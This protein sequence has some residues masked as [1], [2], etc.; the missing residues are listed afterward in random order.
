MTTQN[1]AKATWID[2]SETGTYVGTPFNTKGDSKMPAQ[3]QGKLSWIEEAKKHVG[4]HENV[5]GNTHPSLALW[6]QE[7]KA[8]WKDPDTPWCGVFVAHCL[9]KVGL[10]YPKSYYR[11]L[12]YLELGKKLSKPCYGAVAVKK[13]QGGGHV[14]FVVGKTPTGKLVCLG[15]NQSDMVSYALYKESDFVEFRWCGKAFPLPERYNLPIYSNVTAT[16]V[17]ES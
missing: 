17:K 7:L 3:T 1:K 12:S 15:G 4:V 6:L 14:T 10:P 5:G 13:R 9:K 16:N 8:P 11:A 2:E